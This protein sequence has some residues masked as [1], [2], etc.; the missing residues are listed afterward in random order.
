MKCKYNFE[1]IIKYTD[2]T[3]S[4]E[5]KKAWKIILIPVRFVGIH[6]LL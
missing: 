5:E 4:E 6:T 2:N 3:M 1:D